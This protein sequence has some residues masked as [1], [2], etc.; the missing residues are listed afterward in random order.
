[1]SQSFWDF[2]H[3]VLLV[4]FTFVS[5][6]QTRLFATAFDHFV[7]AAKTWRILTVVLA[8]PGVGVCMANAFM[9]AQ[10][11]HEPPEFVPYSHLRIR[12]KVSLQ[13]AFAFWFPFK[14]TGTV[15]YLF[16]EISLGRWKPHVVPQLPRKRS[17]W[18][19][20]GL[21]SLIIIIIDYLSCFEYAD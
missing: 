9:K 6:M 13:T 5:Q 4:R 16:P 10:D 8:F 2:A 14:T 17:S 21:T 19:L 1:M 3:F 20:R 11:H 7:S 12:T 18:R 15:L